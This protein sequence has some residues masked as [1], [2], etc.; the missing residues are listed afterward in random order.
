MIEDLVE[1]T[2]AKWS[3]TDEKIES[4]MDKLLQLQ[5]DRLELEW[6]HLELKRHL[7]GVPDPKKTVSKKSKYNI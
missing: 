2:T 5:R 6:Q 4:R 3:K 7:A 1:C